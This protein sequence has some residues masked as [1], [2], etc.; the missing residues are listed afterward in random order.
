[1]SGKKATLI[2]QMPDTPSRKYDLGE[3]DR[4]SL[5][6]SSESDIVLGDRAV[7]RHH[8]ELVFAGESWTIH[9]LGSTNGTELNGDP[10][11]GT[12]DLTPGDRIGIGPF[13]LVY[14]PTRTSTQARLAESGGHMTLHSISLQDYLEQS[15]P[16][17][18]PA[19]PVGQGAQVGRFLSSMD[20]VG[21]TLVAHRPIQDLLDIVVEV[22]HEVM[23]AERVALLL[24]D[25]E[26]GELVP[27]ATYDARQSSGDFIISNSIAQ[28]AISARESILSA[29]AM[30]DDRFMGQASIANLQIHSA[31]CAPLWN[32]E[33]VIGILYAD[34]QTAPVSFTQEELHMITLI[35]HLVAVKIQET[36]AQEELEK[37]RRLEEEMRY[38]AEIQQKLLPRETVSRGAFRVG[39]RN[40]PSL[41]VGGDYFDYFDGDGGLLWVA[42]GDVSGKGMSAALL[43]S[44]LHASLR[45]QVEA[46]LSLCRVMPRLNNAVRRSTQG[47][48]FITLFL[49]TL[50]A[51]TGAMEYINAGHNPPMLL[52]ASGDME[53]LSTGG[54]F[55]GVFPDV[56]Y[57]CGRTSLGAGDVL[58]LYSD[59]V[60]EGRSGDDEEFGEE[61]LEEFL[62]KNR[63]LEPRE[64]ARKLMNEVRGFCLNGDPG[65]DVTALIVTS[66]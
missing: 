13:T 57:E 16:T 27:K 1:M 17:H 40:V 55:T 59:G 38:A 48:R 8:A 53:L 47:E 3:R 10:C 7:S 37:R 12:A 2:V 44:N 24:L 33:E 21:Q 52:R 36:L 43:M 28:Q 60:T 11:D 22:V 58:L 25:A 5:G 20:R 19:K 56:E 9:D 26:S 42:L 61:R 46:G 32:E 45:A 14:S 4:F 41:E 51:E 50:D 15:S 49:F 23:S 39:G 64:F 29:D 31:L 54:L 6:R 34:N 66:G 62:R 63:S 35:A 18:R 30:S 65:D